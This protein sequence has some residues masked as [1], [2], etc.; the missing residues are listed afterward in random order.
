MGAAGAGRT[1]LGQGGLTFFAVATAY[2]AVVQLGP[3]LTGIDHDYTFGTLDSVSTLW[4]IVMLPAIAGAVLAAAM[5]SVLGWW[6]PI[7]V[8]QHPV[9]SWARYPI[10]ALVAV[11]VLTAGYSDL[12]DAGA[13]FAVAL[14]ATS[15]VIAC[16]EELVF[17]GVGVI[18]LR[19]RGMGER[20]VAAWTSGAFAAAQLTNLLSSGPDALW[21]VVATAA[22]GYPLYLAR[23]L[24]GGL[25]TAIAVHAVWDASLTSH[26]TAGSAPDVR[27][28]IVLAVAIVVLVVAVGG[29]DRLAAFAE[30]EPASL[31]A[32]V[33]GRWSAKAI[34]CAVGTALLL[35][36]VPVPSENLDA[37]PNDALDYDDAVSRFEQ[38]ARDEAQLELF[39]PCRSRLFSHGQPTDIAVV[40]FHGLTNCPQQFD[41]IGRQLHDAG[42]NVLIVR[43]PHHGLSDDGGATI[44]DVAN[45]GR[46][47]AQEL[48]DFGD[49]SVDI[50]AGLGR[51]VRVLGLSMGG[52]V[53][54]WSAQ[55]RDVDRVVAVAPAMSMPSGP[56]FLTTAVTNL[57]N[58]LPNVSLPSSGVPLDHT[59]FGESTGA[60]S[61]MYLLARAVGNEAGIAPAGADE[62]VVVLNDNDD[63]VNNSVDEAIAES[64]ILSEGPAYITYLPDVGLPHDVIDEDQPEGDVDLVYPI[65]VDLVLQPIPD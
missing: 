53:A 40:V 15:I 39:E 8:D 60:I 63:S 37:R 44:G 56:H 2:V 51:D 28:I 24:G 13:G 7:L 52:T 58:R 61:A 25:A 17:R 62:L 43:A 50:G 12:F 20:S 45:V 32:G 54:M 35:M 57:A 38:I 11:A 1:S 21:Q 49:T 47:S 9:A 59:Y 22:I 4:W 31:S 48:R 3:L 64:M 41:T 42:A 55:F 23:R 34:G 14:L 36:V 19:G 30:D 33:V 29:G 18:A 46:L 27:V 10:L 16:G 6:R 5:T 65:L 26:L